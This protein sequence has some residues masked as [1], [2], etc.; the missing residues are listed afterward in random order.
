M[1]YIVRDPAGK[2]IRASAVAIHGAE[3]LP[4]S[5]PHVVEFLTTHG[6]DPKKVEETLSEL[7]HTDNEM[8]RA[9]EDII[10]VLL[11]KNICKLTDLPK[12]VQ[13][14]MALRVKLRMTIQDIYAHAS[15]TKPT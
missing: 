9:V 8:A 1:P 6:Q 15:D 11:K 13:D 2:I 4:H 7:R 14:R 10:M 3:T 5:H 12:A